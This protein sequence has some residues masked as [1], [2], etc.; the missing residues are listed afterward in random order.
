MV[1]VERKGERG[2]ITRLKSSPG[3]GRL[4]FDSSF[5]QVGDKKSE[6]ELRIYLFFYQVTASLGEYSH[7]FVRSGS[8]KIHYNAINKVFM[9]R[10]DS[11]EVGFDEEGSLKIY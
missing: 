5:V 7:F 4:R 2:T 10:C 11:H 6:E 3:N 8:R 1:V 9:L